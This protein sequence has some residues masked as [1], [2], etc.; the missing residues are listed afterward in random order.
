MSFAIEP[1]YSKQVSEDNIGFSESAICLSDGCSSADDSHISS[2]IN[3]RLFAQ[4]WYDDV[5]KTLTQSNILHRSLGVSNY[6]TALCLSTFDEGLQFLLLGDGFW[7]YKK[8]EEIF[9]LVEMHF[10]GAEIPIYPVYLED[11][12]L[13][14]YRA[15][16]AL[17]SVGKLEI[18]QTPKYRFTHREFEKQDSFKYLLSDITHHDFDFNE[19]FIKESANLVPI[20]SDLGFLGSDGLSRITNWKTNEV[21]PIEEVVSHFDPLAFNSEDSAYLERRVKVLQRT[22]YR[23]EDD[24]SVAILKKSL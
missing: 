13:Y 14:A 10:V 3:S 19:T 20:N 12:G 2:T 17:I 16:E 1:H 23:F 8:S 6:S 15:K 18:G 24:L 7:G 4:H 5:L 9:T 21:M 11:P 22:G